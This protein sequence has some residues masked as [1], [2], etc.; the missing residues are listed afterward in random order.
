MIE[1]L[2]RKLAARDTVSAEEEAVLRTAVARVEEHPADADVIREGEHQESSRLLLDGWIARAKSLANGARQITELHIPGDFVDLHSFMLK[3]LDHNVV[4]L[5]PCR[6]AVVPHEALRR[7]TEQQPHLARLLWL[8]TLIDAS[9]QRQWMAAMGQLGAAYHIAHLLCELYTRLELTGLAAGHAFDLPLTQEEL[10]DAC[11]L[12]SV[13]VNR[14]LRLLREDGL[15]EWRQGRVTIHDW[16]RMTRAAQFD[17]LY[18]NLW[19]E[20]R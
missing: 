9:T 15:V 6:I 17:P 10:G 7:I 1:Q 11:G 5:T 13:H 2:I 3:R 12:T 18:L 14:S 16:D 4:A 8:M 20:P 19:K